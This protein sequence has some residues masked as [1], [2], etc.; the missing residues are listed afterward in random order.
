M[1]LFPRLMLQGAI[2]Y[3]NILASSVWMPYQSVPLDT[4]G[5]KFYVNILIK[6]TVE[7]KIKWLGFLITVVHLW[8]VQRIY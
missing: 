5:K 8:F 6:M 3:C 1:L 4:S 2:Y 7:E